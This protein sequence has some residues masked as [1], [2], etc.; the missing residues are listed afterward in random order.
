ML[1]LGNAQYLGVKS[2]R[3][4]MMLVLIFQGRICQNNRGM[5]VTGNPITLCY[6]EGECAGNSMALK[7]I[8]EGPHILVWKTMESE[9]TMEFCC[10]R[11][12]ATLVFLCLLHDYILKKLEFQCNRLNVY[13][14]QVIAMRWIYHCDTVYSFSKSGFRGYLRKQH[15]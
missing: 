9:S 3:S 4:V 6:A 10:S 5:M 7:G 1:Y 14:T 11:P 12:E 8:A 2:G 15:L 13:S